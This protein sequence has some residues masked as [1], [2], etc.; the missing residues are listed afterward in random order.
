MRAYTS[1][2]II[3]ESWVHASIPAKFNGEIVDFVRFSEKVSFTFADCPF[4]NGGVLPS[5]VH[6]AEL[7]N[8]KFKSSII[9]HYHIY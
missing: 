4:R 6:N 8:W 3:E 9:W 5:S 2:K 1:K 7:G